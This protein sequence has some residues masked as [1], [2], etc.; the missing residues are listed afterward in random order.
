M[1]KIICPEMRMN[2][3]IFTYHNRSF[4]PWLFQGTWPNALELNQHVIAHGRMFNEIDD[5][6]VA[7]VCVIGTLI[8]DELFG[9][10]EKVGHEIIPIGEQITVNGQPLTIIGMFEHYES[11]QEK[12][13][14][15]LEK[16]KPPEST[17]GPAR[18][19][20]WGGGKR[21]GSYVY[22]LK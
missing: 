5:E 20:G 15:L 12:K 9:S 21:G 8:R 3:A 1:I 19:R 6:N 14:R 4:N 17:S 22:R 18:S 11:E 10:P 13:A 7:S 2:R 16:D